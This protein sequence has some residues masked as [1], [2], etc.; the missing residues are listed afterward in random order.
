MPSATIDA[1]CLLDLLASGHTEAVLRACGHVWHVPVAVQGE[2]RFVRQSD[3]LDPRKFISVAVDLTPLISAGVLTVCQPDDRSEL[4]LFTQYA[5][6]FRSD[7]EA[8]CLALA[9]FRG[10]LLATDDK[11]AIRIGQQA[12]LTVLSSPQLVKMWADN[13]HPD[14]RTLVQALQNIERLAQFRP[15]PTMP[16]CPWWLDQLAAP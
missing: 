7:G 3:P 9:E 6:L 8:M 16:E 15:N 2:V 13:A 12:G 11:K 10:W 4:D 5:T 1:C 14:Q